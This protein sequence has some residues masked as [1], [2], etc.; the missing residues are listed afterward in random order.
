FRPSLDF[1]C[2]SAK[3]ARRVSFDDRDTR[4]KPKNPLRRVVTYTGPIPEDQIAQF[5]HQSQ[6]PCCGGQEIACRQPFHHAHGSQSSTTSSV[7]ADQVGLDF[8]IASGEHDQSTTLSSSATSY[9]CPT[10][11]PTAAS[12][13]PLDFALPGSVLH[14]RVQSEPVQWKDSWLTESDRATPTTEPYRQSLSRASQPQSLQTSSSGIDDRLREALYS[15]EGQGIEIG[16]Q[17]ALYLPRPR[18]RKRVREAP[19]EMA[20]PIID[21]TSAMRA[22]TKQKSE[23]IKLAR[24]QGAAVVEMCRRAKADPPPYTFEELIGKGAYGRVYKG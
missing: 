9:A 2:G 22:I 17:S 18:P 7:R 1:K 13:S 20:D 16:D 10:S 23:A 3:I 4:L 5:G 14:L 19:D 8:S 24:E 12:P 15:L 6:F 21:R 11:Q